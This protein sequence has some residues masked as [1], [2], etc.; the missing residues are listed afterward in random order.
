MRGSAD[1]I[2]LVECL[3]SLE[4]QNAK[5]T[6]ENQELR[7]SVPNAGGEASSMTKMLEDKVRQHVML[8]STAFFRGDQAADG[9]EEELAVQRRRRASSGWQWLDANNGHGV[10]GGSS[11]LLKKSREEASRL[12]A[13]LQEVGRTEIEEVLLPSQPHQPHPLPRHASCPQ[14]GHVPLHHLTPPL[15]STSAQACVHVP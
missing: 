9:N 12:S 5:L 1:Y 13:E 14:S 10:C 3:R 2:F 7:L 4:M 15:L 11:N 8:T 6:E